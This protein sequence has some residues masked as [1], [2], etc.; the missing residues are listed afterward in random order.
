MAVL[1]SV[2][3]SSANAK[4]NY[5]EKVLYNFTGPGDGSGWGVVGDRSG[6]LYG[7]SCANGP[8]GDGAVYEISATGV[9]SLLYSFTGG[10]DGSCPLSNLLLVGDDVYGTTTAAGLNGGGTI[11]KLN[12][13]TGKLKTLYAFVPP[14]DGLIPQGP[15]V[16]DSS[17][18][19]YG[20][21]EWGG[22]VN[23]SGNGREGCGVV[24]ELS[25]AGK[26]TVLHAF[27]AGADGIN[28]VSGVILDSS[29]NLYG[30]TTSGDV[31]GVNE[32]GTVFKINTNGEL[33]TLYTFGGSDFDPIGGLVLDPSGNLYGTT[34]WGG[35]SCEGADLDTS[36]GTIFE[37]TAAGEY[38]SLYDFPEYGAKGSNPLASMLFKDGKLYGTTNGNGAFDGYYIGT[39]FEYDLGKKKMSILHNFSNDNPYDGANPSY[40]ALFRDN[41]GNLYG[42]TDFT[43]PSGGYGTIYELS[44]RAK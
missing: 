21:A 3:L 6:N 34:F 32:Y 8:D 33:T 14:T 1:A 19:L 17:G 24:F 27:A 43:S 31:N 2:G 9:H 25:A 29:G 5:S 7:T 13:R 39:V 10:N 18:N 42:T 11:F 38:V 20:T 22:D 23:C 4:T 41:L 44:P 15:L 28:P 16:R 37:I 30:T 35:Y 40:G 12:T 26:Y 36:C